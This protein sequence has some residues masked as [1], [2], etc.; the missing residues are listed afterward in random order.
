MSSF[1]RESGENTRRALL[2]A[3]VT[4]VAE[5]GWDAVTTRQIAQ[6]A[7]VN[8]GLI[9]YHFRSKDQLLHAA[10]EA[11][12]RETFAE[13][14]AA[15]ARSTDLRQA[16]GDMVRGLEP[17]EE[18]ESLALFSV[19]AMARGARDDA[20]RRSMAEMLAEFRQ[21]IAA[22]IA[23]GQWRGEL[24]ADLDPVGAATVLGALLD[25]LGL[26]VLIDPSIDIERTA[27]AA[28]RMFEP[29][30]AGPN[31]AAVAGQTGPRGG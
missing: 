4:L 12:L 20:I 13:P 14:G 1:S 3:A 21:Q 27:A 17:G 9:H 11:A 22:R 10:F 6:R 26:H 19:E 30:Q 28:S 7:G 16:I 15:L 31:G 24:G 5:K 8:Q 25:G 29:A 23:S 18:I 2:N